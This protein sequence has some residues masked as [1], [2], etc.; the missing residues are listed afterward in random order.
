MASITNI[1][2]EILNM[3]CETLSWRDI[4]NL[5]KVLPSELFIHSGI[6]KDVYERSEKVFKDEMNSLTMDS[7]NYKKELDFLISRYNS[8]IRNFH[9]NFHM[10]HSLLNIVYEK[11][12]RYENLFI[13]NYNRAV[14]IDKEVRKFLKYFI[15]ILVP[16]SDSFT[17]RRDSYTSRRKVVSKLRKLKNSL[18]RMTFEVFGFVPSF[19]RSLWIL[20]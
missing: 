2:P 19:P 11:I 18:R 6:I 1:P 20:L 16:L 17:S 15:K 4:K 8:L 13:E 10:F 5:E 14:K 9:G 7:V 3:I 12:V